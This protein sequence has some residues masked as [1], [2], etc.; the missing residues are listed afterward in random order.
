MFL[1]VIDQAVKFFITHP[2]LNQR[3]AFGLPLPSGLM[4][5]VYGIILFWI[6]VY[7]RRHFTKFNRLEILAWT[8]IL[9]GGISNLG[10]RIVLGFVRDYIYVWTGVF[11]LAD[12]YI[13]LGVLI[14]LFMN[15]K[16]AN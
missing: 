8:L 4:F 6:V 9:A 15:K 5:L 11:N 13:I 12:A 1:V 2:F 10:E 14:L 3:F 7:C 16:I